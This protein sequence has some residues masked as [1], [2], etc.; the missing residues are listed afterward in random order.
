MSRQVWSGLRQQHEAAHVEVRTLS[1]GD[2]SRGDELRET[3]GPREPLGTLT[4][5]SGNKDS[6]SPLPGTFLRG[7]EV[8]R[9]PFVAIDL[10]HTAHERSALLR[11]ESEREQ[12]AWSSSA[13]NVTHYLSQR[14]NDH[15]ADDDDF[16]TDR[17][18]RQLAPLVQRA[19]ATTILQPVV[20]VVDGSSLMEIAKNNLPTSRA[21]ASARC[22]DGDDE[23]AKATSPTSM[24]A[25]NVHAGDTDVNLDKRSMNSAEDVDGRLLVP[26]NN[27]TLET[28]RIDLPPAVTSS[29]THTPATI[30]DGGLVDLNW[31]TSAKYPAK[32]TVPAQA[33]ILSSPAVTISSDI[34]LTMGPEWIAI[35]VTGRAIMTVPPP[36]T[37]LDW[38]IVPRL[39]I[40]AVN[41]SHEPLVIDNSVATPPATG[42]LLVLPS[43]LTTGSSA[44][45][46]D[47]LQQQSIGAAAW[48]WIVGVDTLPLTAGWQP[49][50]WD[51]EQTDPQGGSRALGDLFSFSRYLT[52]VDA[53]LP[54]TYPL[55]GSTVE[56]DELLGDVELF[57]LHGLW[58]QAFA[59]FDFQNSADGRA[60][61]ALAT[62]DDGVLIDWDQFDVMSDD[63][64]TAAFEEGGLV[65]LAAVDAFGQPVEC[66]AAAVA[67][68]HERTSYRPVEM[69]ASLGVYRHEVTAY[70]FD[71]GESDAVAQLTWPTA[72]GR[73]F[74][75][76]AAARRVSS[77][78]VEPSA[79]WTPVSTDDED[80]PV[81][82][83]VDATNV[84]QLQHAW[85]LLFPSAMIVSGAWLERRRRE[86]KRH[87]E[88]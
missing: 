71:G 54:S 69:N 12:G 3:L 44:T 21:M 83:E 51:A 50:S 59:D 38:P 9:R 52:T 56:L 42:P 29:S 77:E 34:W 74:V 28:P 13:Q 68:K 73:N 48:Q 84:S 40:P 78:G 32:S 39:E 25:D 10:K 31:D 47:F 53:L 64:S 30:D 15:D 24:N 72:G 66:H 46:V 22:C 85:T 23:F 63:E 82:I 26:A 6:V 80:R 43:R 81:T 4:K 88:C 36:P 7:S 65:E 49:Q 5:L 16:D 61:R 18:R 20:I 87:S 60:E 75:P 14:D 62:N 45:I 11:F 8:T 19:V 58:E 27:Q 1:R 37:A 57:R 86:A 70:R 41:G 55:T 17:D 2:E 79:E 67:A 35:E 76:T 33:P